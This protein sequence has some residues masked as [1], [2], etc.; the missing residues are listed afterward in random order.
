MSITVGIDLGTT[1]SVISYIDPATKKA[2]I[3]KNKFGRPTTPSAV[4]FNMDGSYVIGEEAKAMEEAGNVNTASFYKLHMGDHNYKYTIMGKQYTSCELSSL[5]LKRLVEDAEKVIGDQITDAVITVPAYFEDA[6]KNDTLHAGEAAGLHVINIISEPTAACVAYGLNDSSVNQKI[7]IYD[8]G[9]G[10]FDVTIAEI[11][12]DA[13]SVLATNGHHQLGGQDWDREIVRWMNDKFYEETGTDISEDPEIAAMNIVK[14][15]KA[16]IQLSASHSTEVT[17]SDDYQKVKAVLTREEFENLTSFQLEITTT[18]ID[19]IFVEIGIGWEDINGAVLVGGSTKMPMVR[20]YIAGHGIKILE[21]VHPDEAVAIGAAIQANISN[22]CAITLEDRKK[23][24]MEIT[25]EGGS[26]ELNLMALPGAK[27]IEDVIS[28][29]L[30]MVSVSED[31]S[32][33]LNDIMITR[34]TPYSKA[35]MTKTRELKVS[36]R[37]EKNV[38][39]IYLL[40]GESDDPSDCSIAKR[41]VFRDLDYVEGGKTKLAITYKHTYNGTVDISAVQTETGRNLPVHE[42]AIPED[43]SWLGR[44]PKDVMEE[45]GEGKVC[46]ALI[47]ALDVSGSMSGDMSVAH[48]AMHN[49]V[50]QFEGMDI[51]IG[52]VAFSDAVAA[53]CDPTTDTRV[54]ERAISSIEVNQLS[55]SAPKNAGVVLGYG[56]AASP[57]DTIFDML[58]KF[59]SDPFIYTIVL[60]DGAWNRGACSMALKSR[61]KFVNAGF[62]IIGQGFACADLKF[63]KKL[64]T[65]DDLAKVEDISNLDNNLSS[66]ARIIS[67]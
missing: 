64:S 17:I 63:L 27:V 67:Q 12:R 31:E 48:K 3:L 22:Y 11:K 19:E 1:F 34:N 38:L 7:L 5:F 29:S 46:G 54:I 47:L 23:S 66:I 60:T 15:E 53:A 6:S 39:D 9:G 18:L 20:N 2:V 56:N 45:N 35:S 50:R 62:E 41:Y 8:L 26:S 32:R 25:L 58:K 44:S 57:M 24:S 51:S 55:H 30:G 33:Y 59:A 10:T 65:R 4:G 49:F 16:K 21:G 37:K 42:E 14:A 36:R 13:I 52:I 43:M 40:Q 28:H 61:Q